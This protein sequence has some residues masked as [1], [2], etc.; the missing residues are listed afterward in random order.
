M[1]SLFLALGVIFV[2]SLIP[3]L[4]LLARTYFRYRGTRVVTCPETGGFARVRLDAM[5]AA[6]S[7][8][9]NGPEL[10]VS[11]CDHWPEQKDCAQGCVGEIAPA[12]R[13]IRAA[14]ES[15]EPAA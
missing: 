15:G 6:F 10:A 1:S 8:V 2:L 13:P 7:S 4:F 3:L 12:P 9:S 5:K 14:A 11:S